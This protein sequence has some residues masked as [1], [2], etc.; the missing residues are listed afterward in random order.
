M[1]EN[2]VFLCRRSAIEE[3]NEPIGGLEEKPFH[4]HLAVT[5]DPYGFT[6]SP[7][8]FGFGLM[9]RSRGKGRCHF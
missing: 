7:T 4:T 3:R 9:S 6:G 2:K 1:R 8:E 5:S